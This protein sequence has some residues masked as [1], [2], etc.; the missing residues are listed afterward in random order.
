MAGC[1]LGYVVG[2]PD[3]IKMVQKLCTP[4]NTNAFAMLIAEKILEAPGILTYLIENYN[5]GR[6]YLVKELDTHGY[7]H[8]GDAGNFIFIK[9]KTDA[10]SIVDKM[11]SEKQILI[12]SYSNVGNF[13]TCLRVTIGA[14]QYMERF[15]DALFELDN[16]N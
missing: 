14:R 3:E 16:I 4:H 7:L 8:K 9:P 12:K 5:L 1:R 13:G 6:D 11:K 2:H 10:G 15:L